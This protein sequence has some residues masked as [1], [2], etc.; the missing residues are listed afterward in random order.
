[1]GNHIVK[2]RND[3]V[4]NSLESIKHKF[5]KDKIIDENGNEMEWSKVK[6]LLGILYEYKYNGMNKEQVE[7]IQSLVYF[8]PNELDHYI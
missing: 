3:W 8:D 6:Y 5:G 2:N 1:M 7:K 4:K